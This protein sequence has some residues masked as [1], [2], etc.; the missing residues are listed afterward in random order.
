MKK[1]FR[2]L[3]LLMTAVMVTGAL[4]ACQDKGDAQAEEGKRQR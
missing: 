3:A 1:R 4:T 2:L